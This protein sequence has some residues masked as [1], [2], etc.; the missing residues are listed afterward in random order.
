MPDRRPNRVQNGVTKLDALVAFATRRRLRGAARLRRLLRGHHEVSLTRVR[1]SDN[2]L[3]DLDV[4][5]VLDQAVLNHGYYE[6]E[7]LDAIVSNLPRG[8]VLWDVGANVGL[9]AITTKRLRPDATVVAFEPSPHTAAR[10]IAN[11]RLNAADVAVV[12]SALADS[13]GIARL[14]IVTRGNSGLSSLRPWPD[15]RYETAIM[16]PCA[17]AAD[18]VMTGALPMPNVVKLDVEGFEAE[19]LQ[20]FGEL[21]SMR[22][23]HGLVLEAPAYAVTQS[24]PRLL[25]CSNAP[26]FI[27]SPFRRRARRTP[28][29][30]TTSQLGLERLRYLTPARSTGTRYAFRS[31]RPTLLRYAAR[32]FC[33]G[34]RAH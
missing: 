31:E 30:R 18:L 19:V 4:E 22:E 33:R 2:L 27:S 24:P 8:G 11:C 23:L 10:L 5:N 29:Q 26:G 7:V 14:S 20:G 9:H 16:C 1:T 17:R 25:R 3:F 12:T 21:L 6:R 34:P 28:S 13:N 15:V 32:R